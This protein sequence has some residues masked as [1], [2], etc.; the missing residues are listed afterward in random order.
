MANPMSVDDGLGGMNSVLY[1]SC[2]DAIDIAGMWESDG[3]FTADISN[4]AVIQ[5]Y[6]DGADPVSH[7]VALYDNDAN[8]A[9]VE[10]GWD[11]TFEVIVWTEFAEDGSWYYCQAVTGQASVIAAFE[12]EGMADDTDPSAG[13][14]G[15]GDFAWNLMM[16]PAETDPVDGG[17]ADTP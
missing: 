8:A 1:V 4:E 5:D 7:S 12:A 14:C 3:G 2:G 10:S 6:G 17:G 13:G 11:G 16:A 15:E 9:I